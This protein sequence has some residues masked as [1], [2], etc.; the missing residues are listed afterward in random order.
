MKTFQSLKMSSRNKSKRPFRHSDAN[1]KLISMFRRKDLFPVL[2]GEVFCV[3]DCECK[4]GKKMTLQN[5]AAKAVGTAM[6]AGV[7]AGLAFLKQ[8]P[9]P[10]T[11]ISM[12]HP[13]L[14]LGEHEWRL[15]RQYE[16]YRGIDPDGDRMLRLKTHYDL[17]YDKTNY[18]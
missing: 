4:L 2:E 9:Y 18:V 13:F 3:S 14:T 5:L 15:F 8:L 10:P 16:D 7:T 17:L 1:L 11:L 12:I 6:A